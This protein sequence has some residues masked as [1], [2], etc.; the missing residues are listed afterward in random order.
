VLVVIAVVVVGVVVVVVPAVMVPGV[1][2]VVLVVVV[3]VVDEVVVVE[4][5]VA[6]VLVAMVVE[7][8]AVVGAV[9]EAVVMVGCDGSSG[10]AYRQWDLVSIELRSKLVHEAISVTCA[11]ED[12]QRTEQ[13]NTNDVVVLHLVSAPGGCLSGQAK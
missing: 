2:V 9:V 6:V 3:V 10:G 12:K 8:V 13:C 4:A 11:E 5:A 1:V 7:G